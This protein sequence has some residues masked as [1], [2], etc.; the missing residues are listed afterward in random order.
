MNNY[1]FINFSNHPSS[2]WSPKQIET[3]L[4]ISDNGP[5]IDIDFP[6]IDPNMTAMDVKKLASKHVNHILDLI[7]E[8]EADNA[9]IHVMGEM[10]F[11]YNVV[12]EFSENGY[13]CFASTTK[14]NVVE[15]EDGTK[16]STFE[17]V[18]FRNYTI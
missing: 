3:A 16:T 1:L 18:Q 6:N 5:I 12:K 15:N 8:Y 11:T 10:T 14:R 13:N 7:E 2:K 4:R 9:F 17:F